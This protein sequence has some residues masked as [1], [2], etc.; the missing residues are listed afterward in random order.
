MADG[1][2][3]IVVALAANNDGDALNGQNKWHPG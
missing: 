2:R 3:T 1:Y